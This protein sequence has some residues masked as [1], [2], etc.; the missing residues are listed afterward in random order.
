LEFQR[1]NEVKK[2]LKYKDRA[3]EVRNMWHGET[4]AIP[5]KTEEN[6]TISKH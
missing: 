4:K 1:T 3:M 6:G 2:L 5:L